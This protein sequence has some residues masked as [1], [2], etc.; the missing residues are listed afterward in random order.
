MNACAQGGQ[1]QEVLDLFSEVRQRHMDADL[2]VYSAAIGAMGTGGN[3][4]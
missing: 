3:L 2:V 1:W 4:R